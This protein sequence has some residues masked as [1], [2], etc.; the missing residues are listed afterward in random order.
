M[1]IISNPQDEGG[2]EP[3]KGFVSGNRDLFGERA[4]QGET[5][6]RTWST[7]H[8]NVRRIWRFYIAIVNY[9]IS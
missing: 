6:R 7:Q 1:V 9:M 3:D 5:R 2:N 8:L 4:G